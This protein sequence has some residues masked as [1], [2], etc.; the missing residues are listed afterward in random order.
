MAIDKSLVLDQNTDDSDKPTVAGL[1]PEVEMSS[2][3]VN[4]ETK[5]KVMDIT[6]DDTT[7]GLPIDRGWAWVVLAGECM[8]YNAIQTCSLHST[9]MI[10]VIC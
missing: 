1:K 3:D 9:L 5:E 6:E 4:A 8:F 10:V 7:K 2:A